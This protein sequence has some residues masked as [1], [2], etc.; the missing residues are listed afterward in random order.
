MSAFPFSEERV[1]ASLDQAEKWVFGPATR[2]EKDNGAIAK[3]N[4]TKRRKER[5]RNWRL[6]C[7]RRDIQSIAPQESQANTNVASGLGVESESERERRFRHNEATKGRT[8]ASWIRKGKTRAGWQ[9]RRRKTAEEGYRSC[10]KA[11]AK[12]IIPKYEDQPSERVSAEYYQN[13]CVEATRKDLG[14]NLKARESTSG[15]ETRLSSILLSRVPAILLPDFYALIRRAPVSART[16]VLGGRKRGGYQAQPA[17]QLKLCRD[18]VK[19]DMRDMRG[20]ERCAGL[21]QRGLECSAKCRVEGVVDQGNPSSKIFTV[22]GASGSAACG[23]KARNQAQLSRFSL[24]HVADTGVRFQ[25]RDRQNPMTRNTTPTP[26]IPCMDSDRPSRDVPT[27]KKCSAGSGASGRAVEA[28]DSLS[29]ARK[30]KDRLTVGSRHSNPH[31]LRGEYI[32]AS[33]ERVCWPDVLSTRF[34]DDLR[35]DSEMDRASSSGSAWLEWLRQSA[36]ELTAVSASESDIVV[37][38]DKNDV[39]RTVCD[40]ISELWVAVTLATTRSSETRGRL[41][42]ENRINSSSSCGC[43][44]TG[45]REE[46]EYLSQ[47][48]GFQPESRRAVHI[49]VTVEIKSRL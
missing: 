23:R 15:R 33:T 44:A 3:Q 19:H 35:A 18:G 43:Q 5:G 47:L 25:T 39:R 45:A 14:G 27:A 41:R 12:K 34:K 49:P 1:S 40:C 29:P 48:H 6:R 26:G 7:A 36:Y 37:S 8:S 17:S 10:I 22:K 16:L 30:G 20:V 42:L 24:M 32:E 13:H 38:H 11:Q 2:T 9:E 28:L 46:L 21:V 4:R 31:V